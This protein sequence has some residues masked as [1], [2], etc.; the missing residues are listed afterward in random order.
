MNNKS[1]NGK[2]II[3][4][5]SI[6]IPIDIRVLATTKSINK[7]GRYIKNPIWKAVFNSLIAKAGAKIYKGRF[8]FVNSFLSIFEFSTN[9][10]I[11]CSLV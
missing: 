11:S 10:F 6:N 9:R 2:E 7:N 8:S 5:E 3:T 1:L 4:G